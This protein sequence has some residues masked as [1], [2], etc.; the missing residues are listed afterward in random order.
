MTCAGGESLL[1]SPQAPN[2]SDSYV[3]LCFIKPPCQPHLIANRLEEFLPTD[4]S[5]SRLPFTGR[6]LMKDVVHPGFIPTTGFT[7]LLSAVGLS[8]FAAPLVAQ[9]PLPCTYLHDM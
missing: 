9:D 5:L 4:A 2:L 7:L 1:Q 3:G 8:R 6:S